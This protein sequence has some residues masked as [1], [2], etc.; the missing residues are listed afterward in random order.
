MPLP[1]GV[2]IESTAGS[3]QGRDRAKARHLVCLFPSE[4]ACPYYLTFPNY[5]LWDASQFCGDQLSSWS[6]V[7][8]KGKGMSALFFYMV[9]KEPRP[10]Q[11]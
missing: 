2:Y 7:L 11:G 3:A 5:K 4:E 6:C 10:V 8:V 9:C 1:P